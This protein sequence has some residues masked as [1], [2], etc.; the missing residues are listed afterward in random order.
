MEQ[1]LEFTGN[2]PLLTGALAVAI[3]A[4]IAYEIS[5]LFRKWKEL[6]TL[7][8]VQLLNRED[9]VVIDV[10]NSTDYAKGHIRGA[11]HM[12]PSR[13]ESGNQQLLKYRERPV[14]VYCRNNQV[15]PQMAGR[16]VKLGFTNVNVLGG[17]LSQW[18]SDQQPVSRHKGAGKAEEGKGK[19]RKKSK[20]RK[21]A[22]TKESEQ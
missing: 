12:P 14:L 21:A 18:V 4:F 19:R 10:S 5:R 13:I 1:V 16:L 3:L 7:E 17:G 15:A 11:L 22:E 9:P 8:A 20:D 2:H 6:G